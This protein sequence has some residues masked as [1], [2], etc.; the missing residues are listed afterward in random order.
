M[1]SEK[2]Y[3][4][5]LILGFIV[6]ALLIWFWFIPYGIVEYNL[7][8]NLFTSSIFMVFTVVFLSWLLS[9]RERIQWDLVKNEVLEE[10]GGELRSIFIVLRSYLEVPKTSFI[11]ELAQM[12]ILELSS[13]GKEV[14]IRS[15]SQKDIWVL[16]Y[17]LN[18]TAFFNNLETKYS[19]FI[20]PPLRLSL[21]K[22]QNELEWMKR[23]LELRETY[24]EFN[25]YS[26]V[27]EYFHG[28]SLAILRIIKEIDKIH[29]M[30]I[31]INP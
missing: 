7:G 15:T 8:V 1:I 5:L 24:L 29:K 17:L 16:N 4:F 18:R 2:S 23:M 20:D 12:D 30:G 25:I 14:L 11:E 31:D 22:I 3:W 21:M 28:Q 9:L 27:D 13:L 26:S 19:R 10:L 6:F